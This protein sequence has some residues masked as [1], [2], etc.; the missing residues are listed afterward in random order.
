MNSINSRA[1]TWITGTDTGLSSKTI[2]GVMMGVQ[3]AWAGVPRDPDD[4]GRCY[5]LLRLIP[6]W[7][8]RLPGVERAYPEWGPL[9]REWPRL[10]RMYT[11]A[12]N[13]GWKGAPK[14][15]DLMQGLINEGN[16]RGGS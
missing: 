15:F 9:I 13:R 2:W 3:V 8:K 11:T 10:S 1:Y 12:I 5:R 7:L 14:M 16:F 6:E 4:F